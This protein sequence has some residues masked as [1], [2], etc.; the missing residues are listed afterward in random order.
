MASTK[1]GRRG[2]G[3]GSIYQ[4]DDGTWRGQALIAGKRHSVS[5][6][7][8]KEVQTK[9]RQLQGDADHGLL[10][11][12]EK[13]TVAQHFERWLRDEVKHTRKPRTFDSYSDSARLYILPLVG[14]VRL[15]Q[16]HPAHVQRIHSAMLD[17]GLSAK[18]V[19]IAHSA[20]HAALEQA[21]AWNLAPRNVAALVKAPRIKRRE[22]Q[23]FDAEQ[24]R[25]LQ[26]V[27]NETRWAAL[28]ATAL[29]TGMREGELLGLTW[30]DIDM[31]ASV[32]RVRRQLGRDGLPAELKN[33]K[34]RRSIDVPASTSAILR[35]HKRRQNEERLLV[36]PQWQDQ[37]LV[38]CTHQGKPLGWRNV[39]RE[40]KRLLIR[41]GVP[42]YPFHSLRH[43]NAT[44][45]LVQGVHPKVVQ[46]RL[47]HANLGMTLDIYSH[48]LPR[49]GQ[50]A[51][52]KLDAL[53][54]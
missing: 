47:G 16:L 27:A 49:L 51:P 38:F 48:V 6:K 4:R 19:R 34:H 43:T 39:T 25:R 54:A 35:E 53:L 41:A 5:G 2:N 33:D 20:L 31:E 8:R 28:I 45:L 10:A 50:E 21:V 24:A 9:L 22:V 14:T 11:P 42:D 36:G 26:A 29:A 17:R 30:G 15:A 3:E 23:A 1:S 40:Y 46:E 12:S 13:V 44:L 18:T 32:V 37:G 52:A 7:T